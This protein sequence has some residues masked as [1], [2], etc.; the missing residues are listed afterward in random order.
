LIPTTLR[1]LAAFGLVLA[2]LTIVSACAGQPPPAASPGT[3]APQPA[4]TDSAAA[5]AAEPAPAAPTAPSAATPP[6]AAPTAVATEQAAPTAAPVTVPVEQ[7]QILEGTHTVRHS[8]A[9]LPSADNPR[10]DG[11]PTLVWFS[12]TW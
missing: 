12:A 1:P 7:V 3:G 6:Q 8:T 11:K 5:G 9:P 10:E 4:P 2:L